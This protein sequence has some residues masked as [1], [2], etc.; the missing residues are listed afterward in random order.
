MQGKLTL[1]KALI[2]I[3]TSFICIMTSKAKRQIKTGI[4]VMIRI[5]NTPLNKKRLSFQ[6]I[7]SQ[8]LILMIT[9]IE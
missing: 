1:I 2:S 9:K 5:K 3:S 7:N 8:D 4:K 6:N